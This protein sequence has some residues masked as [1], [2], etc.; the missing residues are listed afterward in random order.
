MEL[1]LIVISSPFNIVLIVDCGNPE[2]L[3]N[4]YCVMFFD[5]KISLILFA[6]AFTNFI[7]NPFNTSPCRS[8]MYIVAKE[9]SYIL[10]S[11]EHL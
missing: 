4:S 2:S 1:S 8:I 5:F 3:N 9:Y 11:I 10:Q 6:T 7:I